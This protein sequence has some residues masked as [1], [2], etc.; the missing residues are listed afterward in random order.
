M[1]WERAVGKKGDD[2]TDCTMSVWASPLWSA[3]FKLFAMGDKSLEVQ[4]RLPCVPVPGA[5]GAACSGSTARGQGRIQCADGQLVSVQQ[6][7]SL[8]Q[9]RKLEGAQKLQ[10]C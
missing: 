7:G 9:T 1:L 6:A 5:R 2:V 3:L 4:G 10:L 8:Y